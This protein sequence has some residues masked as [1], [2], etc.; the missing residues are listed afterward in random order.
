MDELTRSWL[1]KKTE[2]QPDLWTVGFYNP[3]GTWEP[4]SDHDSDVVA[5]QRVHY[6]NGG[7]REALTFSGYSTAQIV[8]FLR[9][10]YCFERSDLKDFFTWVNDGRDPVDGYIDEKWE[11]L[12]SN[13]FMFLC[14]LDPR[15]AEKF[16]EWVLGR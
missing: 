2:N 8:E 3:D 9:R 1:F 15:R 4:E 5:G 14:L 11:K 12:H 13:P 7:S 10:V 16:M 6:L